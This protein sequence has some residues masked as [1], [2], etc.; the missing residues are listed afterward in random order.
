MLRMPSLNITR[1]RRATK[2]TEA[3]ATPRTTRRTHMIRVIETP[4]SAFILAPE[5]FLSGGNLGA[6][7][8]AS[9]RHALVDDLA[10]EHVDDPESLLRDVDIVRNDYKGLP[11]LSVQADHY[12]H[13]LF[14]IL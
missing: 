7:R 5:P 6:P 14:G 12:V 10:V 13:D 2:P 1:L 8:L 3:S 4:K 11:V 9:S